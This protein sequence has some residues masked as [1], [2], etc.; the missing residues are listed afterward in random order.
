VVGSRLPNYRSGSLRTSS[1]GSR[2]QQD[3][4]GAGHEEKQYPG[5]NFPSK[6]GSPIP[7]ATPRAV[8]CWGGVSAGPGPGARAWCPAC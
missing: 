5:V 4:P 2:T 1:R 3:V 8:C 6:P 7:L